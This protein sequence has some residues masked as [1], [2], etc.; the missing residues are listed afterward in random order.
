MHSDNEWLTVRRRTLKRDFQNIT[1]LLLT[2][3]T[4]IF[5]WWVEKRMSQSGLQ[6]AVRAL[7]DVSVNFLSL[8]V[9]LEIV[10]TT[11][12]LFGAEQRDFGVP[13]S[14]MSPLGRDV[15]RYLAESTECSLFGYR[16]RYSDGLWKLSNFVAND[17]LE[18]AIDRDALVTKHWENLIEMVSVH[19]DSTILL[20]T[21]TI[22]AW[23]RAHF[24]ALPWR[25][26]RR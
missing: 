2:F 25:T 5:Y 19:N 11:W 4:E 8:P 6:N 22:K 15:T 16:E 23:M 24:D 7:Y 13:D 3:E 1:K 14:I 9:Q 10:A 21:Q 18:R 17:E 26:P 12:Y 20:A